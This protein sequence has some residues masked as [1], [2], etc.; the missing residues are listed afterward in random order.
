M[1]WSHRCT[2]SRHPRAT[3][4]R[5]DRVVMTFLSSES[6]GI[7]LPLL[8]FYNGKNNGHG[9]LAT[10]TFG[11]CASKLIAEFAPP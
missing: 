11:F 9:G 1:K 5:C 8:R 7:E 4:M 6:S 2:Y 10:K 3:N